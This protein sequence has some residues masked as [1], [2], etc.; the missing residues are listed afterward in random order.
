[1]LH[2]RRQ[3]LALRRTCLIAVL[4]HLLL[5]LRD[6]AVALCRLARFSCGIPLAFFA[7]CVLALGLLV[8]AVGV[9]FSTVARW[10]D[11]A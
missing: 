1:V 7:R 11:A 4:H 5:A 6:D 3:V 10:R 2:P 9:A 8:A